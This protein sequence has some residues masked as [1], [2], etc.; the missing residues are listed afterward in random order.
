M[1]ISVTMLWLLVSLYLASCQPELDVITPSLSP[2]A[3][4]SLDPVLESSGIRDVRTVHE[5]ICFEAAYDARDQI[6]VIRDALTHIR[7]YEGVDNSKLCRQA[8]ERR[9]FDFSTGH[10]LAG[11][12]SYGYGCKAHHEIIEV[13]RD[14]AN[15]RLLVVARFITEGDCAYEL[16]RPFWLDIPD[17][18]DYQ[19]DIQFQS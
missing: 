18:T 14:D 8:V 16:I 3:I 19:I 11:G 5:Q 10:V 1:R 7:F 2:I 15:K 13:Q 12:W 17:A 4:A 9:P 6:F